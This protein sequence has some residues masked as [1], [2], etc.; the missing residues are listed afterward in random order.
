MLAIEYKMPENRAD[1]D[2][3]EYFRKYY[4]EINIIDEREQELTEEYIQVRTMIKRT[5]F[6]WFSKFFFVFRQALRF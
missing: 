1:Y 2:H 3:N 6:D 5:V 4:Y